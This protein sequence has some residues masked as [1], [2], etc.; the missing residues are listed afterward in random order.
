MPRYLSLYPSWRRMCWRWKHCRKVHRTVLPDIPTSYRIHRDQ[1]FMCQFCVK[2]FTSRHILTHHCTNEY[3]E[4]LNFKQTIGGNVCIFFVAE[5]TPGFSAWQ[6]TRE[7][8]RSMWQTQLFKL[9]VM[10]YNLQYICRVNAVVS[11]LCFICDIYIIIKWKFA[12]GRYPELAPLLSNQISLIHGSRIKLKS[13]SCQRFCPYSY[14][15]LCHVGG[16]SPP[17]WHKIW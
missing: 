8:A 1:N 11:W 14:Q 9:W 5:H 2:L 4:T 7:P 6:D 3:G 15:I 17:T 12:T 13:L 10:W 16:T